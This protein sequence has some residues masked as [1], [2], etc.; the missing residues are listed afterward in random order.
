[1]RLRD[2]AARVLGVVL[3]AQFQA[4]LGEEH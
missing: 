4:T 2:S 3:E 1:M